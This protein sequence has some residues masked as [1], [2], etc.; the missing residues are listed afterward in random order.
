LPKLGAPTIQVSQISFVV[1]LV[2]PVRLKRLARFCAFFAPTVVVE[3]R[4]IRPGSFSSTPAEKL[5]G[6]GAWFWC[7]VGPVS[8]KS[9]PRA[10]RR[11]SRSARSTKNH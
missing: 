7:V 6:N 11:A 10:A 2:K 4:T 8:W 9:A 1:W 3:R 5:P